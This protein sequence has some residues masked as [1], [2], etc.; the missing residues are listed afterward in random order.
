MN[1]IV[2]LL[3]SSML[4]AGGIIVRRAGNQVIIENEGLGIIGGNFSVPTVTDLPAI[5]TGGSGKIVH[6]IAPN[7]NGAWWY[8][9]PTM[10]QWY[11]LGPFTDK[12]GT[13]NP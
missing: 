4:G 7:G 5:P 9:T 10:T 6:W 2:S 11:P 1:Q 12:D 3:I 8:A 13:P